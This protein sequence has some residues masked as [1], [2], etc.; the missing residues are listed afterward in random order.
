[1]SKSEKKRVYNWNDLSNMIALVVQTSGQIVQE[2]CGR[3]KNKAGPFTECVVDSQVGI[4]CAGCQYN[5]NHGRCSFNR[6]S[7]NALR[8]L[9]FARALTTTFHQGAQTPIGYLVLLRNRSLDVSL[10]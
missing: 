9:S 5:K 2:G 6:Q 4:A 1:M 10:L 8:T 3:C 7:K